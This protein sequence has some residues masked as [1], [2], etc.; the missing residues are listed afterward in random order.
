[1]SGSGVLAGEEGQPSDGVAMDATEAGRLARADPL[2][3]MLQDRDDLLVGELGLVERSPL[4][5]RE[6]SPAG[7]AAQEADLAVF[8]HE[9]VDG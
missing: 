9:V 6:P 3:Q 2:V 5:F 1:M 7:F 4:V 8:P